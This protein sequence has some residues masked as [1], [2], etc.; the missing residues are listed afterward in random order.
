MTAVLLTGLGGP[1]KLEVREDIPVPTPHSG[2][3]LVQ[4]QAAGINNTDINTR[5]G[6]YSKEV[7][8]DTET[9]AQATNNDKAQGDGT[10]RREGM[11]F[12][13]IQGADVCGIIVAVGDGVL[14]DRIGER[15]LVD[16]CLQNKDAEDVSYFG[17]ECDG[18]FAQ[19][20][21]AKAKDVHVVTCA[22]LKDTELASFPCSYSTAE[23]LLTRSKC[24]ASD[25]VLVTGASGG[26]GS[27]VVQLAKCRGV[28]KVIAVCSSAKADQ[29]K[30][31][32]ADQ[33]IDRNTNV[34]E[35]LGSNSVS[36]VVDLVGGPSENWANLLDVLKRKGRYATAGAI[37][38]PL[39]Q[40]DLRTLYLKDLTLVGCTALDD[41]VF[42]NLI[43][44]INTGKVKPV[45]AQTYP[46][47]EIG[48]AQD[49]FMKK[50]HVGKLVLVP[51]QTAIVV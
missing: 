47:T 7:A 16:P 23:N 18:G 24:T 5:V 51:P 39:V 20:T 40:L 34:L 33:I 45:V 42:S 50:K 15:V 32:G 48:R 43:K 36:L 25:V 21:V 49:D 9:A 30:D 41:G 4:V 14:T 8:G 3:V 46:L 2:E 19:Y 31:L 28:Q 29:V 44:L 26:V 13:R 6:W 22:N 27:A 37:G 10:W 12:P 1:E 35:A 17:S 11:K 38:G